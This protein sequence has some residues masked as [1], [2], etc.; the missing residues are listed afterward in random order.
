[1]DMNLSKL[2]ETVKDWEAW[3]AAVHGGHK[4]QTWFRD[5]T[6][7][8][9]KLYQ[10][11][12]YSSLCYTVGPCWLCF[13]YNSVYLLTQL[14]IYPSL[15]LT[16]GNRKFIFCE[17]AS[18]LQLRSLYYVLRLDIN[19]TSYDICLCLTSL[20]MILSRSMYQF[21]TGVY[22]LLKSFLQRKFN[23]LQIWKVV[24]WVWSFMNVCLVTRCSMY[25]FFLMVSAFGAMIRRAL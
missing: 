9:H 10:D 22:F 3:C 13:I 8:Q 11:I 18:V 5:W 21:S 12:K 6:T 7:N 16:F 20:G 4:C 17:F 24:F 25:K 1:M 14:L 15:T 2:W 19:I 23:L